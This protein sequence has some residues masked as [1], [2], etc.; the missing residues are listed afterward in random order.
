[1]NYI[2]LTLYNT[3]PPKGAQSGNIGHHHSEIK[4]LVKPTW[5]QIRKSLIKHGACIKWIHYERQRYTIKKKISNVERK[6]KYFELL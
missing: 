2:H 3:H 6:I 4:R 5:P 1:M